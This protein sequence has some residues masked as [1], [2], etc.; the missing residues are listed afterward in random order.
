MQKYLGGEPLLTAPSNVLGF[1]KVIGGMEEQWPTPREGE[2]LKAVVTNGARLPLVPLRVEQLRCG[3]APWLPPD[4]DLL[5]W[6]SGT[7]IQWWWVESYTGSWCWLVLVSLA[8]CALS[9]H[10]SIANWW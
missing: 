1:A 3:G 9:P 10:R 2:R 5:A 6:H 8:H 4:P 7:G